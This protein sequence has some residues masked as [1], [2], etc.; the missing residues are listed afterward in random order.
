MVDTNFQVYLPIR[1]RFNNQT[2]KDV[3]LTID[4]GYSGVA[5]ACKSFSPFL[6]LLDTTTVG[7]LRSMSIRR[8]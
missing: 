7:V 3:Q 4:P 6:G 2:R 5:Y 8:M 1:S